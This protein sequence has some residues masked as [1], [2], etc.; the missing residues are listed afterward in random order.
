MNCY[1]IFCQILENNKE[2]YRVKKYF[3]LFRDVIFHP[4]NARPHRV[5]AKQNIVKKFIA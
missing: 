4:D 1:N 3:T 5:G 2:A